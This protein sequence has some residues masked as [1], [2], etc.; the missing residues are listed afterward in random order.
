MG[1]GTVFRRLLA[2]LFLGSL[3]IAQQKPRGSNVSLPAI[4]VFDAKLSPNPD[5]SVPLADSIPVDST[6][7]DDDGNPYIK[8]FGPDGLQILGITT[9][10]IIAFAT[11]QIT[12]VPQPTASNFFV[13]S[14]EMYLLVQGL[15][16][17]RKEEVIEKDEQGQ[18]WKRLETKGDSVD[19]IGRFDRD[20]SYRGSLKLDS[21]F[22]P[23]QLAA[24]SS[25][26]FVIAGLDESRTP[27]VGLFN[28]GGQLVKYLQLPKDITEDPKRAEK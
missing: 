12:D 3:A 7:C 23:M 2:I 1:G 9:K 18:E 22:H 24:F 15:E 27:R 16:N 10:G 20:G 6:Q 14:T 21:N 5:L 13:G 19:Y 11:N 17:A 25:G 4:P 26:T 28:S 8:T